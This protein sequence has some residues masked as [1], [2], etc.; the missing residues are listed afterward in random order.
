MNDFVEQRKAVLR[1]IED[2]VRIFLSM[3]S[4]YGSAIDDVRVKSMLAAIAVS[5]LSQAH[6]GGLPN[7]MACRIIWHTYA[8][9]PIWVPVA[10]GLCFSSLDL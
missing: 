5:V 8:L 2:K 7:V 9:R 3:C 4:T 10:L 1:F 6:E